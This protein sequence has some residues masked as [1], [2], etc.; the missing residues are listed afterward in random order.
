MTLFFT[1]AA[2]VPSGFAARHFTELNAR[3][4]IKSFD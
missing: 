1:I 4:V 2:R 3:V